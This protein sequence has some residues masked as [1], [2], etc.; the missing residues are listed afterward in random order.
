MVTNY[1]DPGS[2]IE[3]KNVPS[4]IS[5]SSDRN[6]AIVAIAP[7]TRRV[8]NE[9]VIRGK[10]Y[11]EG[12][13]FSGTSP[14]LATLTNICDKNRNNAKLYINGNELSIGLWSWKPAQAVGNAIPGT[15]V[16][17][18]TGNKK[19]F[20]LSL[21]KK[22]EITITLTSGLTT[23]LSTIAT[24][25]N[26][27]LVASPNY[28]A[29]Y[30][31]VASAT[32]TVLTLDSPTTDSTS[33]IKI[34][35]SYEDIA[36][37]YADAA[38]LISN[39][40]WAPTPTSAFQA[41][42]RI[43]LIDS[44]YSS[45]ATYT[46]EYTTVATVVDPLD[47]AASGT[48]LVD[49]SKIG[50]YPGSES[51]AKNNDYKVTGNT[52]D[53][54]PTYWGN[55]DI[56]GVV[57]TYAITAT[58]DQLKFSIG[59]KSQITVALTNGPAKTAPQLAEDI[60]LALNASSS[61]GPLYSHCAYVSGGT[62]I[63]IKVPNPLVNYPTDKGYS[64]V[65]NFYTVTNGA[66]TTLFGIP[67]ASLPYEVRGTGSRPDFATTYYTSYDH[68]RDVDDY[69]TYHRV[70]NLDEM[71]DYCSPLTLNNYMTNKL[72]IA[73]EIAFQNQA[74][75]V[76]LIQI[77]DSTV[78]GTPSISQIRDAI[79]VCAKSSSITEVCVIDT[80]LESAVYVQNHVTNMSSMLEKK[81]RRGWYGM[82]RGTD[83]GDPDTANTLI[84]R[85]KI[86][87]QPG[88]TSQ[89]RGRQILQAPTE[90]SRILTLDDRSEVTVD[91]DGSY[92]AC[93]VAAYFTSL[94]NPSEAM[95]DAEI[96][97]F[98]IN[99]FETYEDNERHQLADSGVNVLTMT[100]GR[101]LLLDPLTTEAGGG[102]VVDYEEPQGSSADDAVTRTVNSVLDKNV[103]GVTPDDLAD[104]ISD[105]KSWIK[106]ALEACIESK[107]IA[108]YRNPDGTSRKL[109]PKTD[110]QVVQSPS[111]QRTFR[112]KYW[113]NKRYPAKRFY[114]EYSVD[115]PFWT[116][117]Q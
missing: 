47:Y 71:Y 68:D 33:D 99:G 100:G 49:I 66:F 35:K 85:A 82:A 105:I 102:K 43:L 109:D 17:T 91:L 41:K 51:Y 67:A 106:K 74:S 90:A 45:T 60:N 46:I 94:V 9:A 111:D 73:G 80:S 117:A 12:V 27:A 98:E 36:V 77:N 30:Y 101:V 31:A 108:P 97:G 72:V 39:A 40:A 25:I 28:G 2:Y 24:D 21:D 37:T 16:D 29:A 104:F 62:K 5:V 115:N 70:D 83:I 3:K 86:T 93:A 56:I 69:S 84:Y 75:S 1:V 44:A 116:S 23:A 76:Y 42:T 61:Y 6:L 48:A 63:A 32:T 88:A 89:G 14:Y 81:P 34:F 26:N 19:K 95:V 59:G 96:V 7:R 87:L 57:G 54:A 65:I 52:V 114:G 112:F 4:S 13:T 53:W 103:K 50:T 64:S 10:V 92:L 113:Y 11:D 78:P 20:T 58:N 22:P 79:D 38:S 55:A 18:L 8:T 110:I 107:F 15:S